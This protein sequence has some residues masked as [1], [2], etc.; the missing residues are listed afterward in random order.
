MEGHRLECRGSAEAPHSDPGIYPSPSAPSV[1]TEQLA[2]SQT[3]VPGQDPPSILAVQG[4]RPV[5]AWGPLAWGLGL[6]LG[7]RSPGGGA[8]SSVGRQ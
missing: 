4:E 8:G 5:E 7:R 6:P 1:V 3:G 2:C